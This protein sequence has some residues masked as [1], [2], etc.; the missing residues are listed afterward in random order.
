MPNRINKHLDAVEKIQESI[1][2]DADAILREFDLDRFFADGEKYLV[3][4]ADAFL[5]DHLPELIAAAKEGERFGLEILDN[6]EP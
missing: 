1:R 5:D 3:E 2:D 4:I 6:L